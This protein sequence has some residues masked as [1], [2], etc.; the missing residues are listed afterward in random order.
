MEVFLNQLKETEKP[1]YNAKCGC[2]CRYYK[3][4]VLGKIILWVRLLMNHPEILPDFREKQ[5]VVSLW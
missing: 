4:F 3:G 2:V 1:D 5:L